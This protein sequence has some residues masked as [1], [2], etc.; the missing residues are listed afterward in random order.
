MSG[1]EVAITVFVIG[2][3]FCWVIGARACTVGQ[4]WGYFEGCSQGSHNK[5]QVVVVDGERRCLPH[6]QAAKARKP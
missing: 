5:S 2:G 6:E 4:D 3:F 1:G